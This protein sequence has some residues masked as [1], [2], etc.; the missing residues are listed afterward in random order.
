MCVPAQT[1]FQLET[2]TRYLDHE[3]NSKC[4]HVFVIH[5]F[6]AKL[7]VIYN[8]YCAMCT[9]PTYHDETVI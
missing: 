8:E 4:E 7:M 2:C 5:V 1:L 3:Y 9:K 6:K